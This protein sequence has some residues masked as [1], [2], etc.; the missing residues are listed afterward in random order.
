VKRVFERHVQHGLR[1]RAAPGRHP[2]AHAEVKAYIGPTAGARPSAAHA[3]VHVAEQR[4]EQVPKIRA[5]RTAQVHTVAAGKSARTGTG[6]AG[7]AARPAGL[8]IHL[9]LVAEAVVLFALFFVAEHLVGF[10]NVLELFL[11]RLVVGVDVG[12]E[13]AREFAVGALDFL[14]AGRLFHAEYLVVV[15]VGWS[16]GRLRCLRA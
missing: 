1:I 5:A 16:H 6:K 12:V 11:G 14:V 15:L 8:A 9:P 10:G 13:L 3:P 4:G 7:A 2:L